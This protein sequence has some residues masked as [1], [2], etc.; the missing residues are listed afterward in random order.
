MIFIDHFLNLT[1]KV[2]DII[3][4]GMVVYII[5]KHFFSI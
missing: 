4:T 5:G 2:I 1:N 3:A